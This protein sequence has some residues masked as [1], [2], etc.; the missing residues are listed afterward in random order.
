MKGL[1]T[2]EEEDRKVE[3]ATTRE[4]SRLINTA[5]FDEPE[6]FK[7]V[8]ASD[9]TANLRKKELNSYTI[10]QLNRSLLHDFFSAA[11]LEPSSPMLLRDI[12]VQM[13]G[14]EKLFS[15]NDYPPAAAVVYWFVDGVDKA[16]IELDKENWKVLFEFASDEF[17]RQRSLVVAKHAA[18]MDPVAMAMSAC[19]CSRLLAISEKEPL[20]ATGGQ[21]SLLPS[22]VELE[23]SIIELFE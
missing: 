20:G 13:S 7:G 15:I 8:N 10:A 18:M 9:G 6:R 3:R 17:R 12:A 22:M 2:A 5:T 19:L 14:D 23:R 1:V 4:L 21:H 11:I 16:G